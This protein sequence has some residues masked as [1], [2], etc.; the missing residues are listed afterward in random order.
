[1]K[2]VLRK[3]LRNEQ[4]NPEVKVL[5]P[6]RRGLRLAVVVFPE[7][8]AAKAHSTRKREGNGGDHP[9]ERNKTEELLSNEQ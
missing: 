8:E 4:M 3:V 2:V 7:D 1:M 9:K 5:N 6:N